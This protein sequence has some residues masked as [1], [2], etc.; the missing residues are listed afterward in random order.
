SNSITRNA[1]HDREGKI[2][3][4]NAIQSVN[5]A[6]AKIFRMSACAGHLFQANLSRRLALSLFLLCAVL[7]A[8]PCAATPGE[9]AFTHSLNAGRYRHT[10]TLLTNGQ[11]L[12]AAG[13]DFNNV[14]GSAELYDPATGTWTV[15]GR[16]GTQ[17]FNHTATLLPNGKVLVV[18]G[19]TFI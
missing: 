7:L 19:S 6:P 4:N 12:V 13:S 15:T 18:G 9:W 11:V 17:R 16:L 1:N 3:M 5:T 2:P 8:R 10:A 14:L